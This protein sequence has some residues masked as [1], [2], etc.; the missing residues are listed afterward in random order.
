MKRPGRLSLQDV[1]PASIRL[2]SINSFEKSRQ[3]IRMRRDMGKCSPSGIR[4]FQL[5]RYCFDP[6]N[7]VVRFEL[8]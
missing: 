4:P 3:G 8:P 5:Q 6:S 7:P 1:V 2:P